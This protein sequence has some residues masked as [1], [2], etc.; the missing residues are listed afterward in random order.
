NCPTC[1]AGPSVISPNH[2]MSEIIDL[3]QRGEHPPR[4]VRFQAAI[5]LMI[6]LIRSGTIIRLDTRNGPV[7][8][9]RIWKGH[10]FF[11]VETTPWTEVFVNGRSIGRTPANCRI[12][13]GTYKLELRRSS[14]GI[15]VTEQVEIEHGACM[16]IL[17]KLK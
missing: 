12:E 8:C 17:R 13:A 2:P 6:L 14:L 5:G 15:H 16:K 4:V 7:R 1:S 3:T 11:R 10:G 9:K